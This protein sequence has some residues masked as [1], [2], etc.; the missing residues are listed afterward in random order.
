MELVDD[1]MGGPLE[2]EGNDEYIDGYDIQDLRRVK[3]GSS[4]FSSSFLDTLNMR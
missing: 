2:L 3:V 1:E 4:L